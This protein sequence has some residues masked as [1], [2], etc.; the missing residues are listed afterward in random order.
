MINS[1]FPL[2]TFKA[3][4]YFQ[5]AIYIIAI[6]MGM[7]RDWTRITGDL[8]LT[9]DY[10]LLLSTANSSALTTEDFILRPLNFKDKHTGN[11]H[12]NKC[13][14]YFILHREQ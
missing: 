3:L 13:H 10:Q 7:L 12:L 5:F 4:N 6:K 9:I 2:S 11:D 8:Y 1:F 14:Y